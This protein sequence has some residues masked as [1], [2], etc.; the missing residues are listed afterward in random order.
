M[1]APAEQPVVVQPAL[2]AAIGHRDDVVGFPARL[3]EPPG[4]ARGAIPGRGL[5]AR[6]FAVSLDDVESAQRAHAL[7]ALFQLLTDIPGTTADLPLMDAGVAA[8][9]PA[10]L[11]HRTA[12]PPA[13]RRAR[14]I[15][16]GLAPFL[17]GDDAAP[18]G[19]HGCTIGVGVR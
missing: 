17:G 15:A 3:G 13:D 4:A 18:C 19:A 7:V 12:A 10:W 6:P 16:N 1:T 8:E 14:L 9:R 5:G 11:G 2:T